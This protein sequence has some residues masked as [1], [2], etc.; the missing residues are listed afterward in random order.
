M[1]HFIL[2]FKIHDVSILFSKLHIKSIFTNKALLSKVISLLEG[3]IGNGKVL[4]L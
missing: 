4:L 1:S 3:E 2:Y